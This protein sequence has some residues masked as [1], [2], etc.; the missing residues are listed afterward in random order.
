MILKPVPL[1]VANIELIQSWQHRLTNYIDQYGREKIA[2]VVA[3]MYADDTAFRGLV[4]DAIAS[5]GQFTQE[6]LDQWT[7]QNIV[8]ATQLERLLKELPVTVESLLLGVQCMKE[9]IDR[10]ILSDEEQQLIESDA[11]WSNV[12]IEQVKEYCSQIIDMS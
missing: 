12:T 6:Q 7:Q 8:K 10:T 9:T 3:T 5:K 2:R 1:T 11:Y 4:D